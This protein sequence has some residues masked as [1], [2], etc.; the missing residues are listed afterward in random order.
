MVL[1]QVNAFTKWRDAG[2]VLTEPDYRARI[3]T[4]GLTEADYRKL[5]TESSFSA[6]AIWA[7]LIDDR[8]RCLR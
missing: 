8:L 1:C 4:I 7:V 5:T 6:M 3:C 2:F